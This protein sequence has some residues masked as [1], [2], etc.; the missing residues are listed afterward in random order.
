MDEIFHFTVREEIEMAVRLALAALLGGMIGFER[1]QAEKPAGIRTLAVVSMGSA[2]FTLVSGFGYGFGDP[3]RI[4]AQVVTGIGFLGAGTILR[5][6]ANVRGLTTAASIW[7]V[8]GVGMA[9][10]TGMYIVSVVG[11]VLAL[12]IIHFFPRRRDTS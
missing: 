6:G 9:V 12:V 4:A 7:L 5:I 1:R 11:A 10:G 8:A 3:S 2:M